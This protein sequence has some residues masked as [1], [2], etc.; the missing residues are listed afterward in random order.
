[1]NNSILKQALI[2]TAD[3]M[4][5]SEFLDVE[6]IEISF[7]D[8]FEKK[9]KKLCAGYDKI[10][11]KLT[12]TRARKVVLILVAIIV[13]ML[14]SLS[15]GAVRDALS[16]FFFTHFSNHD[17]VEYKESE[18]ADKE[19]PKTI[20]KIYEIE[21][22]PQGYELIDYSATETSVETIYLSNGGQIVLEQVVKQEYQIHIDNENTT[23]SRETINGI[24]YIIYQNEYDTIFVWDD[25][26]Y[27]FT[28]TSNL[29]KNKI[30]NMCENLKVKK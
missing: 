1:M 6:N 4:V 24:E 29:S 10:S 9:L 2:M 20:E 7:S 8:S 23:K 13:M 11:F 18:K 22:V 16:N 12:R 28:I 19:Y 27:I 3:E 21:S 25:G 5:L 14:A 30:I 15:V 17:V 26:E